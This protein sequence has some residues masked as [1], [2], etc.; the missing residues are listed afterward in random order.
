MAVNIKRMK[1]KGKRLL[2]YAR[3]LLM[4]AFWKLLAWP[5]RRIC[6]ACRNVWLVGERGTDARDNGYQF[7]RFLRQMHPEINACY[8]ISP[9]SPDAGRVSALGRTV[10]F[11]SWQHE[12]LYYCAAV[13]AGT[14]VQPCAPDL[15]VHY[16]LAAWGLHP[17]GVQVFLQH[18][19][20][21]D[22]MEW[23]HRRHL[24]VDLFA[25]GAKPEY[26]AIRQTFGHPE[27]VVRYLGLCRFDRLMEAG[28]PKRMILLMPTWRGA[29]YPMD[30]RFV[31][32][33]FYRHYQHLL[34]HPALLRLLEEQ[35]FQLVFY[36]HVEMQG[37]NT[38]YRVTSP[39]VILAD[40][41]THDVQQLLMDCALLVTDYSSVFFD[42]GFLR[43][44]VIYDQFDEAEFRQYHYHQGYFD[45]RRMG[46][47]PVCTS[48]EALLAA[49]TSCFA[50]QLQPQPRY[51]QR[52]EAF[53]PL[54]DGKNCERT[55]AAIEEKRQEKRH[56]MFSLH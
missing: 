18:G 3:A 16:H 36:P 56:S 42:V 7:Y 11:G 46:F 13:L 44:P 24:H 37:K 25:C 22:E 33:A 53:F 19:I 50:D 41:T 35:D 26:D 55:F 54:R 2:C 40:Q 31:E 47:G 29:H 15:M 1:H 5:L 6:P 17:Q 4:M 49:L 52:M 32:T 28:P 48:E 38:L 12:M 39:R 10:A 14:H 45:Y 34:N 20:T 51:R 43:R 23:L 27:G 30:E 8:V 21:K 9:D